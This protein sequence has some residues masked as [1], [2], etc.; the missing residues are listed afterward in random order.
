MQIKEEELSDNLHTW[1]LRG[2]CCD[3]ATLIPALIKKAKDKNYG[4]IFLDPTYKLMGGRNENA[5]G[6]IG[7]LLNEFEKLAVQT[8]AAVICSAHYSKGNQ[9]GKES[10]DRTSGSGVFGRDPDTIMTLTQH[11]EQDAVVAEFN[12]RN[13]PPM[14]SF[15]VRWD[16]LL[17]RRC[18]LDPT[19]LVGCVGINEVQNN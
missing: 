3:A 7:E 16:N 5:A 8:G 4:A 12:L 2:Y 9:A 19:R 18:D 14:E 13:F 10:I 11:M 15:T 17:F 6:D 1:T